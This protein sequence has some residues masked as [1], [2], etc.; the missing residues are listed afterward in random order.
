MLLTNIH[1][2][3][4]T[5]IVM[6]EQQDILEDHAHPPD[7]RM[8]CEAVFLIPDILPVIGQSLPNPPLKRANKLTAIRS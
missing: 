8:V 4:D 3:T 6:I 7:R 5:I 1:R 2:F